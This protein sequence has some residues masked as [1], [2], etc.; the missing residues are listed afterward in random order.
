MICQP[1]KLAAALG[2]MQADKGEPVDKMHPEN[3]GCGCQ[4]AVLKEWDAM[5]SVPRPKRV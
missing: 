3:C 5:Y 2:R 4:H 1:C